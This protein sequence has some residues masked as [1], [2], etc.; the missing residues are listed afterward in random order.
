V[1]DV[2]SKSIL[3]VNGGSSSLKIAVYE[4]GAVH[5]RQI[6][7]GEV[8]P[9]GGP[10]AALRMRD[11]RH[12]P[13]REE[14]RPL[15]DGSPAASVLA[16]AHQ[17]GVRVDAVGHRLVYGGLAHESPARVTDELMISL[18]A[19]VQ[20][21]PLHTP[22]ALA[23]IREIATASP[24]MPQVV[25]FDTAFHRRMPMAAQRLAIPRELWSE[26]VRRYGF[27]GLSYES[28]VRGLGVTGTRG[29]MIVAHLGSGASVAAMQ[30]GRPV[31]T[32]MG[33]SPLG[34]LMMGTRP[35]DL[36]P[37]VLLYLLRTRRYTCAELDEVLTRRSG[38]LGVSGISADMR[39]LLERRAIDA[40][41]AEAV[42]LFVYQAKKNVGALVAVLD[43]LDTLVFTG[44]IGERA[45]AVRWEIAQGLLHLGIEIDPARNAAGAGIISAE[46]A[47]VVV[48]VVASE[49]NL[50]VARHTFTTLFASPAV[51][52]P[53][54]ALRPKAR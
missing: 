51:T 4:L 49:E 20:F 29:K 13:A 48:R 43:G 27:H 12:A 18:A 38:L 40:A 31:D 47:S 34:G 17:L 53:D 23:T 11:Y 21:D 41:A 52:P 45:A 44:G 24:G 42:E 54:V 16:F 32:S 7:G 26:G 8:E 1:A 14:C 37:G 28:V 10:D 19:L 50:M 25:C 9:V 3:S 46:G 33:F 5:E 39:V 35:G 22:D 36:D 15:G 6:L 2:A 30:D